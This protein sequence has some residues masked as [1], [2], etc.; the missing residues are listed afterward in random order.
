M[1]SIK[2]NTVKA[3]NQVAENENLHYIGDKNSKIRVAIVGN[4]ITRHGIC[5]EIGWHGLYGMAASCIENDYVHV[6]KRLF[7][8]KNISSYFIHAF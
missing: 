6:L 1:D 2:E 8:D 5:P 7:D 3:E 4:S